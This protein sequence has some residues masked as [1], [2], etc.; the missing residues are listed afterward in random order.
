MH[1]VPE[2]SHHRQWPFCLTASCCEGPVSEKNAHAVKPALNTTAVI[3]NELRQMA[4][5]LLLGDKAHLQPASEPC[6]QKDGAVTGAVLDGFYAVLVC[7]STPV[8]PSVHLSNSDT[9]SQ[10]CCN[11]DSTADRDLSQSLWSRSFDK[12]AQ[13][14]KRIPAVA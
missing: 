3:L 1:H 11:E 10:A 9:L 4:Q 2:Q 8:L 12:N 7:M 5:P 13:N 14:C 6:L